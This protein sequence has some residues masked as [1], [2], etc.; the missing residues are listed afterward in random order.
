[1][2]LVGDVLMKVASISSIFV[3]VSDIYVALVRSLTAECSY[4]MVFILT[5]DV[6]FLYFSLGGSWKRN[7][8]LSLAR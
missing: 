6:A 2:V 5:V 8:S 7:S 1:M 3:S 4:L